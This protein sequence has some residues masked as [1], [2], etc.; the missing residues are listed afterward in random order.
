MKKEAR[1]DRSQIKDMETQRRDITKFFG[2]LANASVSSEV[3]STNQARRKDIL[4]ILITAYSG[5]GPKIDARRYIL[6][7]SSDINALPASECQISGKFIYLLNFCAKAGVQQMKGASIAAYN[8]AEP[9]GI[10]L[11]MIFGYSALRWRGESFID[12]LLAKLHKKCPILFGIYGPE[13]TERGRQRLGWVADD[14]E[15]SGYVADQTHYDDMAGYG[16][17]WAGLTLRDFKKSK[18]A[19]NSCPPWNYWRTMSFL[20]NTSP[21]ETT[22]T[23]FVVLKGMI[24]HYADK[25][26][27]NYGQAATVAMRK[28]VVEFPR[29]HSGQAKG[30]MVEGLMLLREVLNTKY[31]IAL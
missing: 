28:A 4:R 22:A 23:H 15:K 2:Q 25:F 27:Q 16:M 18:T 8:S 6:S 1:A 20:L 21:A 31:G 3:A 5:P 9:L 11:A 17:G 29:T 26:I 7:P 24:E 14:S 10:T 30:N 13:K 19:T 12:I